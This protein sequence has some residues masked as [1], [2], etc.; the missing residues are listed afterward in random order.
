MDKLGRSNRH[1]HDNLLACFQVL[2]SL[3]WCHLE[4]DNNHE[5]CIRC[6]E[7]LRQLETPLSNIPAVS[8]LAFTAYLALGLLQQAEGEATS[9]FLATCLNAHSNLKQDCDMV[10]LAKPSCAF[11]LIPPEIGHELHL[12]DRAG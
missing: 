2:F 7:A 11:S 12:S 1:I 10:T 3:S 6:V 8:L 9:E 4:H 5:A